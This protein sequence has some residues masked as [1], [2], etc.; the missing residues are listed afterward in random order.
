MSSFVFGRCKGS[1]KK[2]YEQK[3]RGSLYEP[4]ILLYEL[5]SHD[6][7]LSS[8]TIMYDSTVFAYATRELYCRFVI[9]SS[10]R[11]RIIQIFIPLP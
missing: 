8:S 11:L 2:T 9:L 1:H 5:I 6:F 7:L 3:K 4:L 10:F